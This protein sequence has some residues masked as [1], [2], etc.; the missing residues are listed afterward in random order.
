ML[1][2]GIGS[3][4]GIGP[5]SR[6]P[7]W[8]EIVSGAEPN[9]KCNV[10]SEDA[11]QLTLASQVGAYAVDVSGRYALVANREG[12]AAMDIAY[13]PELVQVGL[14]PGH[15]GKVVGLVVRDDLAYV[16]AEILSMINISDPTA[17]TLIG[18]VFVGGQPQAFDVAGSYAYVLDLEEGLHVIDVSDA[19][20]PIE[21]GTY[22][23]AGNALTLA[24][25]GNRAY[26]GLRE[27]SGDRSTGTLKVLDLTD[28]RAPQEVGSWEAP[29]FGVESVAI[30]GDHL[31][32]SLRV[33]AYDYDILVLDVSNPRSPVSLGR[34]DDI[35]NAWDIEVAGACA[36]VI[37][38]DRGIVVV[39]DVSDPWD[40]REIG[41]QVF[42]GFPQKLSVKG[43]FA[44]IADSNQ[45]LLL[46][47][48]LPA[49]E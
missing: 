29:G 22:P 1:R 30:A 40:P 5:S 34:Y 7:F 43:D 18:E 6:R 47:R 11:E 38:Q 15:W 21:A 24:V 20:Y 9:P 49:N 41:F 13:T 8:L 48:L 27:T 19:A 25:D 39:L 26:V 36:F 23:L 10:R 2:N 45:G 46:W 44:Y 32:L 16:G 4:F 28:P 33:D 12:V 35:Q 37:D 17:P 42:P 31:V 3:Y 14:Y